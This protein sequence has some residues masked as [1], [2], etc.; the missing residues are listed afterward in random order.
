MGEAL[1]TRRGSLTAAKNVAVGT[2][3]VY[4]GSYS[5]N[6]TISTPSLDFKPTGA[7]FMW[8]GADDANID[9]NASVCAVA[10]PDY[11]L[12]IY[13]HT[14]SDGVTIDSYSRNIS[15][16]YGEDKITFTNNSVGF[17]KGKTMMYVAWAE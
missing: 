11:E 6:E 17:P 12:A 16:T 3:T 8:V 13:Y 10:C 5:N 2:I 4:S 9:T 7:M 1:I 15:V 14:T